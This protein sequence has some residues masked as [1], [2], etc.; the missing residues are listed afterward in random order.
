MECALPATDCSKEMLC[1]SAQTGSLFSVRKLECCLNG[2]HTQPIIIDPGTIRQL[3]GRCICMSLAYELLHLPR[4]FLKVRIR[5]LPYASRRDISIGSA[6][7]ECMN[8]I[9]ELPVLMFIQQL[10]KFCR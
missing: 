6:Q 9:G 3:N 8:V 2:L 7:R 1:R 5:Y 10:S 4:Y